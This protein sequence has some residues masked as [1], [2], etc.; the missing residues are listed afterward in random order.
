MQKFSIF[1]ESKVVGVKSFQLLKAD[2]AKVVGVKSF[3]LLKADHAI[4]KLVE[5]MQF[6]MLLSTVMVISSQGRFKSRKGFFFPG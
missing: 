3:Q 2:H 4:S 6:I 1:Q 5:T